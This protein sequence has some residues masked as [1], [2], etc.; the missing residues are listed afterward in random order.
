MHKHC[1]KTRHQ[2]NKRD[3]TSPFSLTLSP[4]WKR[5]RTT[6]CS[7]VPNCCT[8]PANS[9]GEKEKKFQIKRQ[10]L[11]YIIHHRVIILL[12]FEL[13]INYSFLWN[14]CLKRYRWWCTMISEKIS[15]IIQLMIHITLLY[16]TCYPC[17][18]FSFFFCCFH[19]PYLLSSVLSYLLLILSLLFFFQTSNEKK[20]GV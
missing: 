13:L 9:E 15:F 12:L 19:F 4:P 17:K 8:V 5:E 3:I 10:T 6:H 7:S 16:F 1:M 14:E 11:K 18:L 2:I 20:F